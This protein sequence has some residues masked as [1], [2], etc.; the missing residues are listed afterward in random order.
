MTVTE[1]VFSPASVVVPIGEAGHSLRHRPSPF[2]VKVLGILVPGWWLIVGNDS[3]SQAG[4]GAI[5]S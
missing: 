4:S 3:E 5:T 2:V 1:E